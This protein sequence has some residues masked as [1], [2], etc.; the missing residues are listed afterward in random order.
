MG[1]PSGQFLRL[2]AIGGP[3]RAVSSQLYRGPADKFLRILY[4]GPHRSVSLLTIW[5]PLTF[6]IFYALNYPW[7]APMFFNFQG[8]GGQ[9]PPFAPSAGAHAYTPGPPVRSSIVAQNHK[10]TFGSYSI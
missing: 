5:G 4:G 9:M 1:A 3:L 7:G 6:F 8:G 2:L 10:M